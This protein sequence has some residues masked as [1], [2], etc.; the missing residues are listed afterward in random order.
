MPEGQIYLGM[1][2]GKPLHINLNRH[3]LTLAG[4]GAG[5]GSCQII[6]NLKEWPASAVAVD[7]KGEAAQE[8]A[9]YRQETFGQEVAVLDPF[10]YAKVPDELRQTFNPLDMVKTTEDLNTLA[11]GLIMRS[12]HEKDPHWNN[13]A[14]ILLKGVIALVLSSPSI[15]QAKKNLITVVNFLN[16]LQDSTPVDK[17]APL[18]IDPKA[19]A[20]PK[21][22]PGVTVADKA[23]AALHACH[24]FGG[25]ARKATAM[26]AK[27][28]ESS[29][30]FTT[31][32]EQTDW[33][34]SDAIQRFFAAPSTLDLHKLK[35]DKLTVYLV[36][37]PDM[38]VDHPRFLRVFTSLCLGVMW[39]KMP[40]GSELG[41]RCLFMLDEFP[42]LGKM[43]KLKVEG[44]PLGR[45]YGLHVWPFCQAWGQLID[46][47]GESGAES[48]LA[49]CDALCVY[50]VD[51]PRTPELVSGLIGRITPDEL[52]GFQTVGYRSPAKL[53]PPTPPV[54]RA[55]DVRREN[56]QAPDGTPA[57]S[58]TVLGGREQH[59]IKRAK[60]DASRLAY[61]DRMRRDDETRRAAE[62]SRQELASIHNAL[63]MAR[64]GT[65][66]VP[67]EDVTKRVRLDENLK[68]AVS[69]LV[70]RPG[71]VWLSLKL[72]PYYRPTP[73]PPQ[74]VNPGK[75]IAILCGASISPF[76]LAGV[77]SLTGLTDYDTAAKNLFLAFLI[78]MGSVLALG[79][80]GMVFQ[81]RRA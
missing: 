17:P 42:A 43:N 2:D 79:I 14:Q 30:F 3:G 51:D 72:Q 29:S 23:K 34:S 80:L 78:L 8:T 24:A 63:I 47:Y 55:S 33:L 38:L 7:P 77:I 27:T 54:P 76:V 5:K 10:F 25:A 11:N 39:D 71:N 26:L 59:E 58:S 41:T 9:L 57:A 13:C 19:P 52:G 40:D 75:A 49:S 53:H 48:F 61:D 73:E 4:S 67:P 15:P 44:L 68:H 66:R 32:A 56:T 1:S 62:Q 35:R 81:N 36:I 28:G 22:A 60:Y 31:L 18:F 21:A 45:S 6:P 20:R 70:R 46:I 16:D 65:P 64:S 50:G 74:P 37:P 69:M 12:E